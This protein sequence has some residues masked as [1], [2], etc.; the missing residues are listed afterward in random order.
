MGNKAP[1]GNKGQAADAPTPPPAT[2]DAA[3]DAAQKGG[4]APDLDYIAASADGAPIGTDAEFVILYHGPTKFKGRAEFLRAMLEDAGADYSHS[5]EGL[6]G[7]TGCMDAFRGSGEAV[8]ASDDV[9]FPTFFPPAIWHRPKAQEPPQQEV[10]VNQVA[11]CITYLG[12]QLGYSP[13]SAAERAK[14]DALTQNALDFISAGRASFHPVKN[15]MS[16]TEQ[17]EEGDKAS[18]EWLAGR[19]AVFLQHF[20]KVLARNASP[21]APVAGGAAATYA[22]FALYHVLD[23]TVTQFNND[24]YGMFW[25]KLQ[26]PNLKAFYAAFC[27]RPK[28]KAYRASDRFVP[29][30]GD[31]M[32]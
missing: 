20:E 16:Y 23:A 25:D 26:A 22:D 14:A 18:A 10:C 2:N 3:D 32:M 24:K 4:K 6:Y 17:R 21:T 28:L 31:S 12:E 15:T 7:P 19:A 30:A 13:A 29:F 8:A 27:E 5:A 9:V 1:K 11:A